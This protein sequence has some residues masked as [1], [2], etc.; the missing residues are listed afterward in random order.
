MPTVS[1]LV[2]YATH[3]STSLWEKLAD[4][5]EWVFLFGAQSKHYVRCRHPQC[6]LKSKTVSHTLTDTA[7]IYLECVCLH[8]CLCVHVL[9]SGYTMCKWKKFP[10][11]GY[12]PCPLSVP[13]RVILQED[14]GIQ[15]KSLWISASAKC[16]EFKYK[17]VMVLWRSCKKRFT[18]ALEYRGNQT[19]C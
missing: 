2:I 10:P 17:Y 4:N 16:C 9:S 18:V 7:S 5:V 3:T 15:C 12:R 6:H 11:S 8:L 19:G 13:F 1:S 14:T